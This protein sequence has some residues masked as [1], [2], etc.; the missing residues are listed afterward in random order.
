MEEDWFKRLIRAVEEH[1]DSR[2]A[3]SLRAGLSDTYVHQMV[4]YKKHPTVSR[5]LAICEAIDA[6][7]VQIMTGV[8]RADPEIA[9]A[10]QIFASW[11]ETEQKRFLDWIE[12]VPARS[13]ET[14]KETQ[15]SQAE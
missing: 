15:N 9:R 6:D 2:R 3:I 13:N 10:L 7:P 14:H 12:T 5:F 8:D 4:T 11:P 1:P